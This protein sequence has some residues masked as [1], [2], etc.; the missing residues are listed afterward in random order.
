MFE[1]QRASAKAADMAVSGA[2][3]DGR[4]AFP[5]AAALIVA[6][7]LTAWCAIAVGWRLLV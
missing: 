7:S 2:E 1:V 5:R 6:M 3:T 4:L